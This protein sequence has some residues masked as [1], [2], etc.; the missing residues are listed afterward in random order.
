MENDEEIF[1]KVLCA[2]RGELAEEEGLDWVEGPGAVYEFACEQLWQARRD[3]CERT[4]I[5]WEDPALERIMDVLDTLERD[6][7]RRVFRA[8]TA[9]MGEEK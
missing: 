2:A 5:S 1:E 9:V 3:L 6:L 7:C 4:G 8:G